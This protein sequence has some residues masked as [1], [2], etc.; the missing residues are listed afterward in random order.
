M[1][2][3]YLTQ[4]KKNETCCFPL[5]FA[6][7]GV[8]CKTLECISKL[9]ASD[10]QELEITTTFAKASTSVVC[11]DFLLMSAVGVD[12]PL[13]RNGRVSEHRMPNGKDKRKTGEREMPHREKR[14]TSEE[15]EGKGKSDVR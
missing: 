7:A 6:A 12:A 15:E 10:L 14:N 2:R 11:L 9:T 5:P 8:Y 13:E 3:N 4:T 1:R